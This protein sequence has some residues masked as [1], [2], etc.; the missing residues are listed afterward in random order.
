MLSETRTCQNCKNQFTIEPEDFQ[1][2]ERIK[3]PAPTF[4]PECRAQR[5]MTWRNERSLYKTKDAR[6]TDVISIYAPGSPFTVY[7]RD[8]WWSDE[9]NPLDFG[10]DVDFSKNFFVQ[11]RELLE[12]APLPALFANT[13]TDSGYV[14]HV[15]HMNRCYLTYASWQCEDVIY[16]EKIIGS[17]NILDGYVTNSSEYCYETIDCTGCNKLR[18]S[19]DCDQCID[20]A[21]LYDCRNCQNCFG[22]VGLRNKSYHIFN[23]PYPKEEYIRLTEEYGAG[24]ES[25][26]KARAEFEALKRKR[27]RKFAHL[28]N[29]VDSTGDHCREIKV[30]RTCF[31]LVGPVENSKYAANG[32]LGLT[33]SYDG[34]G[35][36]AG[37]DL[38]YEGIDTGD[39]GSL[40]KFSVVVYSSRNSDYCFNCENS[41]NLFGC[42]G[43][44]KKEY[45]ILNKQY[46]KEE[47][48]ALVPKLI[49]RMNSNPYV[50]GKGRRYGYGEFF[51]TELSPFAYN[52]TIAQEYF[53]MDKAAAEA[54][55]YRWKDADARNYEITKKAEELPDR[56][57]DADDGIL[58][59]TVGCQHAGTCN[60]Q[61]TTAFRII[62]PELRFY[63]RMHVPLPRLCPNCRHYERLAKRNPLKLWQRK[64]MCAGARAESEKYAN[65]ATHF[66]GADACPNEFQ[67]SYAPD[68]PEIVYCESCYNAEI[69]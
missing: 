2:Y 38:L 30:C 21:F 24:R 37:A 67:T 47:Y 33:D 69:A 26:E 55:G 45:C 64:C 31:D 12:R 8:Y 28:L 44:R 27:P 15:G 7:E 40:E 4:C 10:L 18:H 61:C 43:L 48:E 29:T 34:Y 65:T 13:I 32:G 49:E 5:R 35:V 20:S 59:E 14:N 25:I 46:T 36:G 6:G 68:R 50:D 62:E 17:K 52:E 41:A 66:H 54:R 16:G 53:P 23:K 42:V 19:Q 51:P 1:F 56:I 57:A 9:W 60:H 63:R 22:C 58:K 39:R 11:F 3:V